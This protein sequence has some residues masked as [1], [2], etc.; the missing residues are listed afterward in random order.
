MAI[1]NEQILNTRY[2]WINLAK[3]CSIFGVVY[4]HS[5]GYLSSYFRFGVPIFITISFFLIER[6]SLMKRA[7]KVKEFLRKRLLR[8]TIPYLFWGFVYLIFNYQSTD[9]SILKFLSI[10]WIGF[11]WSGQYYLLILASLTSIYPL[12]RTT[13]VNL[14]S[15][16]IALILTIIFYVVFNYLSVSELVSKLGEL[17]LI[18]WIFYVYLGIYAA[19]NYEQLQYNLRRIKIH[20][21][22]VLLIILPLI[23]V[24]ENDFVQNSGFARESYFRISTILV[25]TLVFLLFLSLEDHFKG[26]EVSTFS[27]AMNWGSH[28]T[29]GI[30]CLNPLVINM[31]KYFQLIID[32]NHLPFLIKLALSI[33]NCFAI[34]FI[35]LI[36]SILINQLRGGILVK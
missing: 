12:L 31:V 35:A 26:G 11:G 28:W 29:L 33:S 3:V 13:N 22:L 36:I 5:G 7:F 17:P 9:K 18:Y 8:L 6:S 20:Y 23:M 4:I 32:A 19:R 27:R 24:F 25:S 15:L 16:T 10:H 34:C 2:Q 21:R 30:Y 14:I 1:A